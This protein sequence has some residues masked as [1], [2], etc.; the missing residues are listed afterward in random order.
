MF[1]VSAQGGKC[2]SGQLEGVS[3]LSPSCVSWDLNLRLWIL[4]QVPLLPSALL[5]PLLSILNTGMNVLIFWFL[6]GISLIPFIT[7]WNNLVTSLDACFLS[8]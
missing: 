7:P 3:V 6:R 5:S 2:K 1:I 8:S 4:W